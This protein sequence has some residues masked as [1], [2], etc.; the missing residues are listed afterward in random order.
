[1]SSRRSDAINAGTK[2][3]SWCGGPANEAPPQLDCSPDA[4][5]PHVYGDIS[6]PISGSSSNQPQVSCLDTQATL[7]NLAAA[8]QH[9]GPARPHSRIDAGND[10][11]A[12]ARGGDASSRP[13]DSGM[14]RADHTSEHSSNTLSPSPPSI[15]R[16]SSQNSLSTRPTNSHG[17]WLPVRRSF[18]RMTPITRVRVSVMVALA[19]AQVLTG[20]IILGV[21]AGAHEVC[22]RPLRAFII[23]Y[24]ARLFVYYPLYIIRRLYPDGEDWTETAVG[25]WLNK[26]RNL[27]DIGAVVL[28]I[29]GNYWTFTSETCVYS[30]PL[31][32]YTS[33]TYIILGYVLL[34][35]PVLA[36]IFIIICFPFVYIFMRQFGMGIHAKKG[37]GFGQIAKIPLVRYANP[38]LHPPATSF[39]S[40]PSLHGA[41]VLAHV[42][43]APSTEI[44][45]YDGSPHTD[46]P[47]DTTNSGDTDPNQQHQLHTPSLPASRSTASLHSVARGRR[48]GISHIHFISPFARIAHRLTRGRRQRAE[49]LELYKKQ[50]SGPIPDFI[51]LCRDDDMCAICLCDYEDGDI[52][53]VLPCGHHLH[54]T[55]VDEWLHIN[56][57]CPLCKRAATPGRPNEESAIESA[58][59]DEV[60]DHAAANAASPQDS[61][62]S[63]AATSPATP[64]LTLAHSMPIG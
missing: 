15:A 18:S 47:L 63:C 14:H 41:D 4:V 20:V 23:A 21:S 53:R 39:S 30:A 26:L 61:A 32:Y 9:T 3:H 35:T 25:Y 13:A 29:L 55:C 28:F 33:L 49:E 22:D 37:A 42:Q 46:A 43:D 45:D 7:A 27:L 38:H 8:I 62:Q 6:T 10:T 31:L 40:P 19:Y 58:S 44:S 51:P 52:L 16:L 17:R 34:A 2:T 48:Y 57:S 24:I 36:C 11:E 56:Q 64:S 59:T 50:L 12:A 60:S 5:S 1:M 54:Q